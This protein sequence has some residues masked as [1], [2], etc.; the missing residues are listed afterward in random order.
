MIFYEDIEA[1]NCSV[2]TCDGQCWDRPDG[3]TNCDN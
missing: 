1:V 2:C 3:C